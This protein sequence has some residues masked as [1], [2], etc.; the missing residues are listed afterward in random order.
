VATTT[1]F[2]LSANAG[3]DS[4]D[5]ELTGAR[6]VPGLAAG[7]TSVGTT[8]VTL[9]SDVGVG[10]YYVFARADADNTVAESLE[11]NNTTWKTVQIGGDLVISSVNAPATAGPATTFLITDTTANTGTAPVPAS[12]TRFYLSANTVLDAA[13]TLLDGAHAVPALAAGASDTSSTLVSVPATVGTGTYYLYAKADADNVVAETQESNNLVLR[14]IQ[15]GAD[16]TI[17][18]MTVPTKGGAGLPL[19]ISD[20][21]TNRG[22]AP[23]PPTVTRFYL[24]SNLMVDSGD[25]EL[26]PGRVVPSLAPGESSSGTTTVMVPANVSAG[27]PYLLAQADG[28]NAAAEISETNN[29]AFRS[30]LIGPDLTASALSAPVKGGI[31][32]TIDV[33]N[34]I[35]NQG[36][37]AAPPSS[38]RYYL[39]SNVVL[40]STARL[41]VSARPV[42]ALGPGEANTGTVTLTIPPDTVGG[43]YYLFAKADGDAIVGESQEWNNTST[44][45][46]GIGPD[47]RSTGLTAPVSASAGST[48]SVTDIVTN[49][50]IGLADPSTT[51][52][53]L[54]VN[55]LYDSSDV[56][57]TDARAVPS[58]D[59]NQTSSGVTTVVIPPGTAAGS[60]F[61]LAVSDGYNVVREA[62]ET[63]N[64]LARSIHVTTP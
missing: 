36:A 7:A 2:Y 8:V 54:S 56:P 57:L 43:P 10:M 34:T 42:P 53:Y 28:T 15:I 62:S 19:T 55:V 1:R 5:V 31:G 29:V 18:S 20:T 50:G 52:F 41:F 64:A 26:S 38:V 11:L 23:A 39:S 4:S 46:I 63:N 60:Y 3:L 44:R 12:T 16:L 9:P 61:L 24:S 6:A 37:G 40:D 17:A 59:T 47:L 27:N 51:R 30:I 33:T 25:V 49:Q 58:L 32:L 22:A 45:A 13:D 21:T 35:V 14:S 48:I